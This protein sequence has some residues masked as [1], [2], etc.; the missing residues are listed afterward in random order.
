[1]VG[2][3]EYLTSIMT[4]SL[5]CGIVIGIT[6]K[7]GSISSIIKLLAGLFMSI[8]VLNPLI[9][10]RLNDAQ[11]FWDNLTIDADHAASMGKDAALAEMNEIIIE[12]TCAYILEKAEEY[13]ADIQIEIDLQDLVPN[14]VK[15]SGAVSPYVKQQLSKYIMTNLGISLEDQHWIG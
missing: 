2:V 12:R 8:T 3:R 10:I 4:A 7:T 14:S 6:R 9:S 15:I 1:M 11:L 13:G 5:I